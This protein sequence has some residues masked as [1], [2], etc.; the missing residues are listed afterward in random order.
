MFGSVSGVEILV[1]MVLALILF[2]PRQ[3]PRL[4]R[5]LGG[6]LAEFRKATNDFKRN[7]EREVE[8]N[9]LREVGGEVQRTVDEVKGVARG[10]ILDETPDAGRKTP[11][12]PDAATETPSQPDAAERPKS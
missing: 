1:V 5:T 2:G 8:L 9:D 10:A 7:L 12:Q 4:G 11:P 6:A 3:L